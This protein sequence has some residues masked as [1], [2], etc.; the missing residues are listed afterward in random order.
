MTVFLFQRDHEDLLREAELQ[1]ERSRKTIDELSAS[2]TT[3]TSRL[4]D[5]EEAL[6]SVKVSTP[7]G[8]HEQVETRIKGSLST[9]DAMDGSIRH[10]GGLSLVC[11]QRPCAGCYGAGFILD[12]VHFNLAKNTTLLSLYHEGDAVA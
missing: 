11:S 8:H 1:Q 3:L 5:Q 7:S 4:R 6:T 2:V 10:N 9:T 12:S